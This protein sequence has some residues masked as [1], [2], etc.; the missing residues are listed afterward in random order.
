LSGFGA[1]LRRRERLRGRSIMVGVPLHHFFRVIPGEGSAARSAGN[2]LNSK[3]QAGP[4]SE[5][6]SRPRTP[7]KRFR[8][9]GAPC[10]KDATA[11]VLEQFLLPWTSP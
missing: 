10:F 1:R 8:K 3:F 6:K 7:A 11:K 5:K 4:G 9:G 2:E